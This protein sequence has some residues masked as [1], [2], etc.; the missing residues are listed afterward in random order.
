[1]GN[2][3]AAF[4][5]VALRCIGAERCASIVQEALKLIPSSGLR[6]D[7]DGRIGFAESLSR[8][9]R[10]RLELLDRGFLAYPDD[11]T[12][13]LFRFVRQHPREFGNVPSGA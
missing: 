13:L 10:A 7:N 8:E 4:A 5:P 2:D 11:L 9:T 12:D 1:V 6:R 3:T